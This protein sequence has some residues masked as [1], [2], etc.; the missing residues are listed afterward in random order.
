[1]SGHWRLCVA[2]LLLSAGLTTSPAISNPL[3][4]L[5]NPAPKEAPPPPAAPVREACL[6]QPGGSTA[7]GQHWFYRVDGHR[8][9]WY[10][11]AERN[12]SVSR[13]VHHY[14]TRRSIISSEE[15]ESALRKKPV[16]D[17]RAQML[18]A[19]LPE[20][21]PS[22]APAPEVVETASAPA[23]PTAT[24]APAATVVAQPRIEQPTPDR[25][26]PRS[27]DVD[28]LLA[29]ASLARDTVA[30]SAPQAA[31]VRS[32]IPEANVDRSELT[33]TWMGMV[34]ITLGLTFLVGSMLAGLFLDSRLVP[35]RRA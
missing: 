9:C 13:S 29:D 32:S 18:S 21:L 14:P 25:T 28:M 2:A 24:T 16:A 7:P 35:I 10:Q 17:A 31:R 12:V 1:M 8:K 22:T 4:D 26:A 34:L 19:A 6:H 33:A 3:T 30:S 27:V 23:N 20:P 5:L 15:D 11:A